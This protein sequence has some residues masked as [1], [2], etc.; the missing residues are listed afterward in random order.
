MSDKIKQFTLTLSLDK[1]EQKAAWE[2]LQRVPRGSRTEY[3]CKRL[4]E[5]ERAKGL[6]AIVYESAMKALDEYGSTITKND[7][8]QT[9][10]AGNVDNDILGFL[11]ALQ[12]E[13]SDDD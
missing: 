5:E 13:G 2:A 3:I 9:N 4:T 11:S 6:A 8:G 1:P 10:Q 7:M 12:N